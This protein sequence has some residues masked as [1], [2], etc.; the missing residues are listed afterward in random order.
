[1]VGLNSNGET[2]WSNTQSH[3]IKDDKKSVL[4]YKLG[5]KD[6]KPAPPPKA[7]QVLNDSRLKPHEKREFVYNVS[8]RDARDLVSFKADIYYDLL[9]P[10]IK[11]K[12]AKSIPD[13]LRKSKLIATAEA[14]L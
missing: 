8:I 1:M 4:M 2:V 5:D 11:K 9:L 10:P 7:T 6:G 13:H 12:F 14:S 3:P